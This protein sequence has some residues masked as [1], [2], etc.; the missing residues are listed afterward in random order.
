MFMTRAFKLQSKNQNYGAK[1]RGFTLV[2]L[3]VAMGI[4]AFAAVFA[5]ASLLA[6][7]SVQ[8]KAA[9]TQDAFDNVRFALEFM[10]KET[11]EAKAIINPCLVPGYPQ[12]RFVCKSLFLIMDDETNETVLYKWETGLTGNLF[13][14]RTYVKGVD[15][16]EYPLTDERIVINHGAFYI[17][18]PTTNDNPG[19]TTPGQN[20]GFQPYVIFVINATAGNPNKPTEQSTIHLQTASSLWRLDRPL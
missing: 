17:S 9:A 14:E 12:P 10:A 16:E 5:V 7:V 20:N 6:L 4:F 1:A 11:R 15:V 8:R 2:E 13:L 3:I 19:I 18:D